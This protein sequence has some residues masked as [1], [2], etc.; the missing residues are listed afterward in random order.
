MAVRKFKIVNSM[1]FDGLKFYGLIHVA[2][3]VFILPRTFL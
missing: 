1:I 2:M 3:M